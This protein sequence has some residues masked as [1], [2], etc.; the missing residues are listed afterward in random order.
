MRDFLMRGR[1]NLACSIAFFFLA[2]LSIGGFARGQH[3]PS[4]ASMPPKTERRPVT[5]NWHGTKI[6]DDYRWLENASSPETQKWVAEETAYTRGVLDPLPGREAI[7]KRLT[8]LLSI[9]T[10]SVPQIG[11]K[12]YF[13]TRRDG[14]QNQPVLYVREGFDLERSDNGKDRALV[15]VNQLA[16]DGTVAPDWFHPSEDGRY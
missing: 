15:D 7:H 12:Y 16:A 11:G 5:E 3:S 1:S 13:Y 10:V 6:I 8:E 14:L 2:F 4:S 9:G